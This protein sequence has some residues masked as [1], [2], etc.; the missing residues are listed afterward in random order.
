MIENTNKL[1]DKRNKDLWHE[2]NTKFRIRLEESF[3]PNYITNF[4]KNLVIIYVDIKN[5][6]PAPF[7]HE[8]L[9]IQLKSKKIFTIDDLHKKIE[10]NDKVNYLFSIALKEHIGNCLEHIKI[11]P[12]FINLGFRNNDFL[13]DFSTPKMTLKELNTLQLHFKNKEFYNKDAIDFFIGKF[14][15]MKACNN[16]LFNYNR[17]YIEFARLDKILFTLLDDFWSDWLTFDIDNP[18]DTY[19]EIFDFFIDDIH[20][21]IKDKIIL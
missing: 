19:D 3:E 17:Y 9:H 16:R 8:L 15:A 21:W 6:T 5:L 2:L 10:P 11:L 14:I 7:T 4:N 20:N 18:N 1:L 12:K 13:S